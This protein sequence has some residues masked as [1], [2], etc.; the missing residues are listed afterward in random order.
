MNRKTRILAFVVAGLATGLVVA[1]IALYTVSR[2]EFGMERVRRFALGWLTERVDGT[3]HI[4]TIGGRG[5]LGGVTVNDLYIIDKKGRP[6]MRADSVI[7]AYNW[8]TLVA[9]DIVIE[10]A[11]IHDPEIYFEQLPGDSVWNYQHVFPPRGTQGGPTA[12]RRLIMFNDARVVNGVAV[13]RVPYETRAD[14]QAQDD[15]SVIDTVPGGL[16][17]RIKFDSI[18]GSLSRFI[19][20][21]PAEVGKLIDIRNMTA[22]G[23]VWRDPM[24]VTGMRGT[25]TLKDT[26]VAFDMPDVRFANSRASVVGRVIQ[27]EGLNFFDVKADSRNFSFTDMKW[28]YPKLPDDGGG[29]GI[30]RIQSQRPKGILWLATNLRVSAP[31]TRV[32]GSFGVVTGADSLYFTN[33]DMRASPL[34]LDL[35]QSML[36]QKLPIDGLLVGT[37]E[38]KGGLSAL[39]TKGDMQLANASGRSSMKWRGTIDVDGDIGAR[40]FHADVKQLDLG[41]VKAFRPDLDLKGQVTGS[42]DASG[43]IRNRIKFSADMQHYFSGYTSSFDGAGTYTAGPS[44]GL[45]LQMNANSLS[46]E[47]LAARYP[48]LERLRGEARGPIR[49]YGPLDDLA[50]DAKL[51]TLGGRAE[52]NGKL[53]RTGAIPR[54]SGDAT[55]SAFRLDQLIDGLPQTTLQGT[56]GF[57]VTGSTMDDATGRI[58]TRLAGGRIKTV[59]FLDGNSA[60]TL[61][62]GSIRVDTLSART[63][64]G[65]VTARGSF[66]L[67]A[68]NAGQIAFQIRTDSITPLIAD[69]DKP[70]NTAG[71]L[72]IG[73]TVTG[74]VSAFDLNANVDVTALRY[75][76]ISSDKVLASVTGTA[77]GTDS[78]RIEMRGRADSLLAFGESADTA[79]FVMSFADHQGELRID[80]GAR[81]GDEYV[82]DAGFERDE[83]GLLFM[84]RELRIGRNDSPWRLERPVVVRTDDHGFSTDSVEIRRG[85][86]SLRASGRIAWHDASHTPEA[87]A[88]SDFRMDFKGVPFTEFALVSTGTADMKGTLDGHVRVTG[89][90][91]APVLD[92]DALVNGFA[93]GNATLDRL[94]GSF[95]YADRRINARID[96]EKD[97]RRV[98]FADGVI[99]ADLA[100]IPVAQRNLNEPLRFSMQ[101]DSLPASFATAL[102]DGFTSVKGRIDGTLLATGT[103]AK[104]AVGGTLTLKD[105]E[106]AWD[107]SGVRYRGMNATVKLQ[108]DRVANVEARLQANG[109]HGEVTGT[110]DFKTPSDPRFNLAFRAEDFL[111]AHRR[112]AELTGSGNVQLRG[113]YRQPEITG[114]LAV[115]RGAL[116][117][118]ELYRRYQIIELDNPLLYDVV[119]TS[120]V[121]LRTIMPRSQN[122][123][124][125]N[126]VVN[127]LVVNV[128]RE[129]W[130]RSRDLNVE[131]TGDIT[132]AFMLSDTLLSGPRSAQDLIMTG[133]LRAVRG[134]YQLYY[135]GIQRQ[136]AIREGTVEFPGTPGVDPNLAFNATY[137]A[138]PS[139]SRGDPIDIIAVVGGTL[140]RPSVRLTSD[141]EPPIS[142][143]DLASY[144]FF[145][146]PTYQLTTSQAAG[147]TQATN[148]IATSVSGYLASGLQTFVQNI[149]LL[150]YISLTAA[151]TTPGLSTESGIASLFAG[152]QLELGRYVGE[153]SE[154]YIAYSQRLTTTGFRPSVRVQWRIVP[155]LTGEVFIEDRFARNPD[156]GIENTSTAR[157]VFGFFLYREWGY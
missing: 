129:A 42:F 122:P 70:A 100:F 44:P 30:L 87:G 58:T 114:V 133:T 94:S 116:F 73:G 141:E 154:Y 115:D 60:M 71:R 33:V 28:L 91:T 78:S 26:I 80:A 4:G 111:A 153:N 49:L 85:Q 130:L 138:R 83:H 18:N 61:E 11:T 132:I 10:R 101:A 120:I 12:P 39:E 13:V 76:T 148:A 106:A 137:R 86:G 16:A 69:A 149:G 79:A 84:L 56:I 90:A 41:L 151:E 96:G 75:G 143:S 92:G 50:F 104:P 134:T 37:V 140:M 3:V 113:R 53:T 112:D 35:M 38:I 48:A 2:T 64:L 46:L 97:N 31:G 23:F 17:Q 119:D 155:T 95:T 67:R 139:G 45:D 136:F 99:P 8:R 6:F 9:G 66:G 93:I 135:P 126:L 77:L 74:Y 59:D 72:R 103:T 1:A 27:E 145:G 82:A 5:L 156:F 146:V 62:R 20:E 105:G 150:D 25:V 109:G 118:D 131:V 24:R 47:E 107:V 57:D 102:L 152:Q 32:S 63:L 15:R 54:Y 117:L 36:P 34:N 7:L 43:Q 157:K 89:S 144:L 40:N 14:A 127:D 98:F 121:S 52:L 19:W 81:G 125:R 51:E 147:I 142:E 21:S 128:G 29:S 65:E 68:E 124:V 22:R 110:I 88:T 123:F 55:L 108:A